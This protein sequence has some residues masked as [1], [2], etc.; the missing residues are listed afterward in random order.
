MEHLTETVM[1]RIGVKAASGSQLGGRIDDAGN[2]HGNDEI[3]LTAGSRVEDGIQF[4]FVQATQDRGDMAVRKG[5]GDV[6]GLR[7]RRR[8]SGQR[9]GQGQAEGFDLMRGEM[10]DVG[11]GATFDFAA[12]AIGFAEEN[13]GRG[14]AVGYG[15]D[16]HAYIMWPIQQYSK[17]YCEFLHAYII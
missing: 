1:E 7:Q 15:G 6:K 14:V 8:G 17:Q 4:Q 12:L 9:T 11:N 3:A 10:S 16:V 5:A 2:D 13:S